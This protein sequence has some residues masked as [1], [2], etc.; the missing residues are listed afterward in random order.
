MFA[1]DVL[2]ACERMGDCVSRQHPPRR[3]AACYWE[4]LRPL[5][6]LIELT[7]DE[8]SEVA[9]AIWP[10]WY[11]H[12]LGPLAAP[13]LAQSESLDTLFGGLPPSSRRGHVSSAWLRQ[14]IIL[15]KAGKRPR[16]RDIPPSRQIH[17]LALAIAPD[18]LLFVLATADGDDVRLL[19]FARLA[20]WLARQTQC[21]VC[22]VV[23]FER[24]HAA[25]LSSISYSA[26]EFNETE[27]NLTE[28]AFFEQKRRIWPLL[29]RPH[30]FSPGEQRLASHLSQHSTLGS[31]FQFNAWVTT[32]WESRYLVDLVWPTGKIVVEVDG[33]RTHSPRDVFLSD[34]QRDYELLASGYL[35]LRITHDEIMRDVH[36]AVE[37]IR[38]V[39]QLRQ[40]V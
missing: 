26:C 4:S 22:A 24:R 1:R 39:V 35:V 2:A 19:G 12:D 13:I 21:P 11:G 36:A 33:Y 37:K 14:A 30:P 6:E 31:L 23:P 38:T 20:E 18:R 16:T 29:G 32:R 10:H 8:L 34:R 5:A 17:Q 3:M 7:L 25:P 15:L 27:V 28:P 40:D 9:E